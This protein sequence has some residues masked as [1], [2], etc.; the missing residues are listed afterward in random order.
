M[1]NQTSAVTQNVPPRSRDYLGV[2][3]YIKKYTTRPIKPLCITKLHKTH[4]YRKIPTSTRRN[5]RPTSHAKSESSDF[6][7]TTRISSPKSPEFHPMTWDQ[8]RHTF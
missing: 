3:N 5:Q 4:Q 8:P 7:N 2:D 1:E 6:I